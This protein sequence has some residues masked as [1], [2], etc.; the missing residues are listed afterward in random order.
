MQ[1]MGAYER[2][3]KEDIEKVFTKV[4]RLYWWLQVAVKTALLKRSPKWRLLFS[5][6]SC[7][8]RQ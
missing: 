2:A 1:I 7:S 4:G 8:M 5:L 3:S 6:L